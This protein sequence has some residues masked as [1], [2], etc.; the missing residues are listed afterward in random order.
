MGAGLVE[1]VRTGGWGEEE[2]EEEEVRMGGDAEE[3]SVGG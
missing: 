2:D 3:Q 1:A